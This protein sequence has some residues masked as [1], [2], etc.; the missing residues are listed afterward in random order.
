MLRTKSETSPRLRPYYYCYV[1][2]CNGGSASDAREPRDLLHP[3]WRLID[4][5]VKPVSGSLWVCVSLCVCVFM[6]ACE[7]LCANT[8]VTDTNTDTNKLADSHTNEDV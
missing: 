4:S 2:A 8:Y 5:R 3:R 6:S 1:C 7:C